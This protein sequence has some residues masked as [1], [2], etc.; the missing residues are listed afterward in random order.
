MHICY[1]YYLLKIYSICI[2]NTFKSISSTY[3]GSISF[4]FVFLSQF[5]LQLS[6]TCTKHEK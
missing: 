4:G 3:T 5:N 6:D 2:Y 1:Y